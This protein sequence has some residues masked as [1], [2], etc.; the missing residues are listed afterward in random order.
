MTLESPTDTI[1]YRSMLN[2]KINRN[3]E[4]F[5]PV[6]F[7]QFILGAI[8]TM[9]TFPHSGPGFT[10]GSVRSTKT[11]PSSFPSGRANT[12]IAAMDTI[13]ARRTTRFHSG[14]IRITRWISPG[15]GAQ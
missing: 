3:F 11:C 5:D 1:I 4:V 14:S 6:D 9:G 10:T 7:Y 12:G 2:P 15:L 13:S 8:K